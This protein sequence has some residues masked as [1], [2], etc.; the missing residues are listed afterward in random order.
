MEEDAALI[1]VAEIAVAIAGFSGI[2]AALRHRASDT[3]PVDDRDRFADL[4]THSGIALFASLVPLTFAYRSG[5]GPDLWWI[6]SCSWAGFAAIGITRTIMRNRARGRSQKSFTRVLVPVAFAGVLAL[7]IYNCLFLR[8]F[9]PYLAGL[10][11]NLG[12]AFT[13]FMALAIPRSAAYETA[14]R[15]PGLARDD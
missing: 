12:F 11:A 14:T 6:S 15:T 13:Q 10:V 3:W 2:A 4:V 9:W 7:Q 1:A 5:I 8:E